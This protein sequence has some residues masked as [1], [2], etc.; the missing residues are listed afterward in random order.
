MKE[1][2]WYGLNVVAAGGEPWTDKQQIADYVASIILRSSTIRLGAVVVTNNEDEP[3]DI[4]CLTLNG[5]HSDENARLIP[6]LPAIMQR[7]QM[8]R[9]YI[10]GLQLV[11]HDIE[12]AATA[13][14][15]DDYRRSLLGLLDEV[16]AL[17]AGTSILEGPAEEV[18]P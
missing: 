17:Q 4:V 10:D 11:A 7:M 6:A 5:P 2:L 9:E 3:G 18:A 1:P 13:M 8:A 12:S 14:K 15:M 16:L